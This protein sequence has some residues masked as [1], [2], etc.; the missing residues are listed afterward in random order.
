MTMKYIG[1]IAGIEPASSPWQREILPFDYILIFIVLYMRFYLYK[2]GPYIY[3]I[4]DNSK[5]INRKGGCISNFDG[6]LR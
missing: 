3:S 6:L 4:R 1:R 5:D 2:D